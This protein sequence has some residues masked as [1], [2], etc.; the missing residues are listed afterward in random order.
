MEFLLPLIIGGA[1][2]YNNMDDTD[3]QA[4]L[5]IDTQTQVVEQISI[6]SAGYRLNNQK[7]APSPVTWVFID[8]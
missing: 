6:P 3:T 2:L 1:L 7:P 8:G 4:A 5:K